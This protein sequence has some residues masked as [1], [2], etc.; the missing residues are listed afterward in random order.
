MD[1]DKGM[2]FV[3]E[4]AKPLSFWMKNT[5]IP[6][7]ILF[8]DHN[9]TINTIHKNTTPKNTEIFYKS[10]KPSAYAIEV[11]AGFCDK[12]KISENDHISI[13]IK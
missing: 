1:E 5:Y 8:I 4:T 12:Y 10:K 11:N 2:L 9:G 6:L 7:D 13:L 3:F